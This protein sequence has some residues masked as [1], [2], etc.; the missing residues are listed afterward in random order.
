MPNTKP[1][2]LTPEDMA[3]KLRRGQGRAWTDHAFFM[4]AAAENAEQLGELER[5]PGLL[6]RSRSSWGSSTGSL[7]VEDDD[8]LRDVL[9]G[10]R[11]RVA[12]HCED[13][14]RLRERLEL[15]RD[16]ADVAMHPV[17]ARRAD[18]DPRHRAADPHRPRGPGRRVVHVLHVT[19]APRRWRSWPRTRTW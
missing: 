18:G 9:R 14:A 3:D 19:T 16:G 8:T 15:V 2:T 6:R 5:L 17:W 11:R 4:G 7:L 1:S 13:E 12:V 10:G